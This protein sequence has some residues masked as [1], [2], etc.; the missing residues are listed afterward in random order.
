MDT[1]SYT[2]R[3]PVATRGVSWRLPDDTDPRATL[4]CVVLADRA[5]MGEF[6]G[7]QRGLRT[8]GVPS[9]RIDAGSVAALTRHEDGSLTIDGRRIRPT[10]VWVRH[11]GPCG[12]NE[13]RSLFRAE[14]WAA[15]VD[16][17]TALSSVRIP[18][19][20]DPG[21]LAQ[22]D[23]AAKAGIRV[24]R[25]IV[26]TDP[27]SAPF[28]G[29]K[30]V[31]KALNRHFVEAEPGLLEGVFPEIGD[32]TAFHAR[33]VPMIVQE[34]V[35]H[36]AELRVYHVDGE[37]RAFRVDK[38]SPAAIWR[39]E[40]SVTVTPV[41]VPADVAEAVT[42]LA[43][44]WGLR[45]GAFDFLLTPDGPVFLEVNPDGDWRWFE[46]KAG[47]DDISMATLAMVRGL[48]RET[49][50]IDLA[51][52]LLLGGRPPALDVRVLGPLDLRFGAPVQISAR[53]SRL[54]AA[55]LLSNPNDVV[56]TD[57]LIDS[58]WSGRPPATARKNLQVYVSELRKRLGD[59][60]SYEGWG[61]R[62]DAQ[63]DELDLLRFR[64]LAGAGREMR[65]RGAGD[66]ALTLL[67]RALNLWRGRP[68]AE[69]AGV[70]LVDDAV[71]RMTEL[72]LT[73]NEDWA[74]LQIE[75]GRFVDVLDRLDGLAA[76]FPARERLIAARMTALAHCG[77]VP[78]ALA[79]FEAV[80]IRLSAELG[81]DPSPV[82]KQ[83]YTSI[84]MGKPA[85]RPRNTG[86]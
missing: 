42:R 11:F 56:P 75:R 39:D 51:G 16:Q 35:E 12:E 19:G 32:R 52:F 46:S 5:G 47:V 33:D 24:P 53:K 27:A 83:L 29:R 34:Y 22:L 72:Y 30:V 25:T 61:Y 28:P 81:I 10:V 79:Q 60:I 69:F 45:Y 65:R 1:G 20:L 74:E 40:G 59:R 63:R 73:L 49:T 62:L 86:G 67:D 48:H 85:A 4:P 43:D 54:L 26:T 44:L 13:A 17:V 38:P 21:R 77:R 36:S 8:L 3:M 80:R 78:E 37:I 41:A 15:L 7:L 71:G 76:F 64:E 23:G 68:L 31:V 18:D 50:R 82:L 70:P 2:L 14:S 66:A 58:L 55:I 6:A 57:G 84:L 9:V